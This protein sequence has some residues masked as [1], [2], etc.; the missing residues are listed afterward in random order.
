MATATALCLVGTALV[1]YTSSSH[2]QILARWSVVHFGLIVVVLILLG[3]VLYRS[4][5]GKVS[6]SATGGP[7]GWGGL[8]G[9]LGFLAWAAGF[10]IDS[11]DDP[12]AGGRIGDLRFFSSTVPVSIVLEWVAMTLFCYA[13]LVLA[14]RMMPTRAAPAT[15]RTRFAGNLLVVGASVIVILLLIEGG[16]RFASVLDPEVQ[17]FP[18]RAQA[19]W[20]RRFVRLNSL[21]YRDGEH[22]L[23]P[24][25][26]VTRILLI[27]DS[28]A[29]GAGVDDPKD[30]VGDLLEVH[31]NRAAGGRRFEV[32]QAGVPDTHTLHHIEMLRGLLAFRPQFVILLYV[33]NDIAHVTRPSAT[34]HDFM[35]RVSPLW[36]LL[37]QNSV[38]A[39]Q[40][41]IR[42]RRAWYMRLGPT[43]PDPYMNDA[44]LTEHLRALAE[45]FRIAREAGVDARLVPVDLTVQFA[46]R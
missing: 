36:L 31:L 1:R 17:G 41:F 4:W 33:F 21:G 40:V 42:V 13:L 8:V 10:V 45:F 26:G 22:T 19:S 43:L 3:W 34:S 12:T 29:Y 11:V 16:L 37:V 23:Q 44:L 32:V 39:E 18:T 30:R 25:D 27:G 15:R 7:R 35:T 5:T 6:V 9:A 46:E 2:R 24:R 28:I 38:A 14:V 20:I